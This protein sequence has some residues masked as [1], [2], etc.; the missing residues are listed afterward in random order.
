MA[1]ATAGAH[2][3]GREVGVMSK[4]EKC[5]HQ[6]AGPDLAGICV[7][8]PCPVVA[9]DGS[10]ANV[11][12]LPLPFQ[13]TKTDARAIQVIGAIIVESGAADTETSIFAAA[14]ILIQLKQNGL[15]IVEAP[16]IP[17]GGA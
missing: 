9:T 8:C 2:V 14:A 16:E 5:G 15:V 11:V 6:H 3:P 17:K 10:S 12:A 4:C 7:G 13:P 1:R